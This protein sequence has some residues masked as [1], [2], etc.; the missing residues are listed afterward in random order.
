MTNGNVK[1]KLKDELKAIERKDRYDSKVKAERKPRAIR[2]FEKYT[3]M[4]E[5][6]T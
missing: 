2:K 4:G 3:R 5:K 6:E 1:K